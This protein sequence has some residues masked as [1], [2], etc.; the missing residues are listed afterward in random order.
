MAA[1]AVPSGW[2]VLGCC[3]SASSPAMTMIFVHSLSSSDARNLSACFHSADDP[4][5][6]G[7]EDF[8]HCRACFARSRTYF[9]RS[10]GARSRV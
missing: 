5:R 7:R 9:V 3:V 4:I 10:R 8:A 2:L 1:I 6:V